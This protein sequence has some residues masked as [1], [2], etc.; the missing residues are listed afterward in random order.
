MASVTDARPTRV[1]SVIRDLGF[2]GAENRILNMARAIDPARVALRV[3]TLH[4]EDPDVVRR[5]GSLRREFAGAGIDVESLGVPR[6]RIVSRWRAVQLLH[7]LYCHVRAVVALARVAPSADVMDAHLEAA[8]VSAVGARLLSRT[9]LLATLYYAA[10]ENAIGRR[11]RF[12][13]WLLRST[14]GLITDSMHCADGLRIAV[15]MHGPPVSVIPNGVHLPSPSRS[16]EQM[17]RQFDLDPDDGPII[18][19]ISGIQP[20]KGHRTLIRALPRM[21]EHFPRLRCVSVGFPRTGEAL[22]DQLREEAESLGVGHAYRL[23]SYPGSIADVWQTIDIHVHPTDLD[24][25]PNAIIEGMS[26]AKPAV[27]TDVGGIGELV[28]DRV[29]GL[30][31][32]PGDPAQLADAILHLLRHPQTARAYGNAARTRYLERCAPAVTTRALE[33]LFLRTANRSGAAGGMET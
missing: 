18:G 23:V 12:W 17:R 25:L 30:V 15:G 1:L 19:Q 10:P 28:S 16:G 4:D 24:S 2:G 5:A 33:E 6:T 11:P 8:L 14:Q 27:V 3:M 29:T 21:L 9:P 20:T 32:P 22:I 31:V 7:T 26:L 13:H